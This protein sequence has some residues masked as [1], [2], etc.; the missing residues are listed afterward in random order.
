MIGKILGKILTAEAFAQAF[1]KVPPKRAPVV[2]TMSLEEAIIASIK[3]TNKRPAPQHNYGRM[4]NNAYERGEH[5]ISKRYESAR[6]YRYHV[7]GRLANKL[8]NL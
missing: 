8:P 3:G 4:L 1:V 5:G 7:I 6:V 2:T